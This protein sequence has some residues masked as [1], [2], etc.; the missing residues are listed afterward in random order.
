MHAKLFRFS[1]IIMMN[2]CHC[3]LSVPILVSG[4]FYSETLGAAFPSRS[5][6]LDQSA[7]T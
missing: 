4:K 2:G 3:C 6:F 5:T 7:L 1:V